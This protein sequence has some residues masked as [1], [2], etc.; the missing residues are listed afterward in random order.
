MIL[1]WFG[2][3]S[4]TI[5]LNESIKRKN[6]TW[7]NFLFWTFINLE[8]FS[9]K[10]NKKFAIFKFLNKIKMACKNFRFNLFNKITWKKKQLKTKQ[11]K[12]KFEER[13]LI[14]KKLTTIDIVQA[15][16][17]EEE[18]EKCE[19]R[20]EKDWLHTIEMTGLARLRDLNQKLNLLFIFKSVLKL[21]SFLLNQTFI[22]NFLFHKKSG[23]QT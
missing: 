6:W 10:K 5:D 4:Q 20:N 17:D 11:K 9:K 21:K 12:L 13:A 2:N 16:E 7:I 1:I 19:F 15:C 18:G 14:S 22:W 8:N 3:W 23:N